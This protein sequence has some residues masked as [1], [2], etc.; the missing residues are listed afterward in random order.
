[1]IALSTFKSD[2]AFGDDAQNNTFILINT[3]SVSDCKPLFK[4]NNSLSL[5]DHDNSKDA[6]L[7][8]ENDV[9]YTRPCP[10]LKVVALDRCDD[11]TIDG[12]KGENCKG[13]DSK[14]DTLNST[15]F[16]KDGH[17]IADTK[18]K[19]Q[20]SWD[21]IDPMNNNNRFKI[22]LDF[23]EHIQSKNKEINSP[24]LE[25]IRLDASGKP[26]MSIA[27][28]QEIIWTGNIKNYFKVPID[29]YQNET[30]LSIQFSTGRHNGDA[31][32]EEGKGFGVLFDV[33][34]GSSPNLFEYRE[35]GMYSKFDYSS[36]KQ[37]AQDD[38]IFHNLGKNGSPLFINDLLNKDDVQ[39]KVKTFITNDNKRV[40]ETFV[41]DG[42][43]KLFPYWTLK[44]LT[45][46]QDHER[47]KDKRGFVDTTQQGSGYVIARTDN[48]DTRPTS[49]KS[50][51]FPS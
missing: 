40:I 20:Y 22:N 24:R 43:G 26:D 3:T 32:D 8:P 34:N 37:Y 33:S 21:L 47:I 41:D 25:I 51:V 4:H 42:S 23:D 7:N 15:N 50:L 44:D 5:R 11:Q 1:M 46:L 13:E 31:P 18:F 28:N 19:K 17:I 30:Y 48:I 39:L 49:F 14:E 12:A 38:F 36:L 10:F 2:I 27:K 35:N 45:K 29:K 16:D 6:L 9:N